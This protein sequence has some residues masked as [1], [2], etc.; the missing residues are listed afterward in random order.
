ML[1][2]TR[3]RI[4]TELIQND[5]QSDQVKNDIKNVLESLVNL[6]DKCQ[7]LCSKALKYGTM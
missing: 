6:D 1:S 4:L 7:S 3:S 2:R 5:T